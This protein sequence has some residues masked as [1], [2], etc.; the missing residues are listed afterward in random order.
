MRRI[1]LLSLITFAMILSINYVIG[2][3]YSRV[4]DDHTYF[5]YTPEQL[6]DIR[7]SIY[8]NP[9]TEDRLTIE[10]NRDFFSVEILD[11]VGKTVFKEDYKDGTSHISINF[12]EFNKGIYI[13][14]VNFEGKKYFTQKLLVR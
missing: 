9:L 12:N 5:E 2:N 10:S 1:I 3:I 14:K 11:V 8:P 7:V 4:S 13:V 6:T